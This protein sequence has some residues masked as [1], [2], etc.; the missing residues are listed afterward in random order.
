M[1]ISRALFRLEQYNGF[2]YRKSTIGIKSPYLWSFC[3]HY[4][5]GKFS[6]DGHYDPNLVS[7]Q[8][9]AGVMLR[10]MVDTGIVTPLSTTAEAA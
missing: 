5:R 10:R 4:T 2:G 6:F 3:Q 8:C 7:Q 9:G 1:S